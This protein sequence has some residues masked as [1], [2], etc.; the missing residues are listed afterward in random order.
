[1]ARH[2]T[3][4]ADFSEVKDKG[5]DPELLR[6]AWSFAKPYR[7]L[8]FIQLGVIVV[9]QI[10]SV[11]PPVL[12]KVVIDSAIPNRDFAM[13][14]WIFVAGVGLAIA[15]TGLNLVGRWLDARVGEGLIF[16]L[17]V[18]LYDHVQRMP[19][20]FFTR[21]Q[22]GALL[23][24][25]SSDVVGAQRTVVQVSTVVSDL[26][27]LITTLIAMLL[28][29]WRVTLLAL[30]VVP[31]F[32]WLDRRL[33]RRLA[34]ISRERMQVDA[35][36]SGVMAERFNVSGAALVKLFGK[37]EREAS[38]FAERADAVRDAGIRSALTYRTYYGAV[39]MV[40][41]LGTA[42]V[43]WLGGRSVIESGIKVGT[44]V[45]M[46]AL[47]QR[48]YAPLTSLASARV[49]LLVALVS[50][51]RV[52]EIL[53]TKPSIADHPDA[54][55]IERPTGR[56]QFDQ[57]C[58]SYPG[59]GVDTVA[60]LAAV[61]E[62]PGNEPVNDATDPETI[63]KAS[64][65][66]KPRQIL[67]DISFEVEPGQTFALVGPSG[68][69]KTTIASLLPRLY[70]VTSGAIKLDGYD[71]RDLT[72]QSVRDAVGVVSQDAHL[73]HESIGSNLRFA[74]PDATDDEMMAAAKAARI[75]DV[76]ARLPKGY[77]TV[78][79]ERGYRL[80]GGEKQRLAIARML[81]K[82]PAVV[83]LDEATAHLD[84]ETEGLVQ[85]ALAA[86]LLNRSAIVI[87]HRLSTIRA[88]DQILVIDDGRIV[89]QGT[90]EQLL[91]RGGLYKELY[92]TQYSL[93]S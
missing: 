19:L 48:L 49:D 5:I 12:F 3:K 55:V 69:G 10:A 88:A 85:E 62:S 8:L 83:V 25:L 57:V 75:H 11:L 71:V 4:P 29:D 53:D 34:T 92:E 42:A 14:N 54:T 91:S 15:S 46:A 67:Y 38:K 17:R 23:S 51:E 20:P 66:A 81:L 44:L 6:R 36:M 68:A 87:A 26:V 74:K 84:S 21:T 90:H 93:E 86:A 72:L 9:T 37:P 50:F 35:G 82:A 47:V 39:A 18:A 73:F 78:V 22:T 80:S 32:I 27:A 40:S 24:R 89:Q 60:S 2:G 65:D 16:D 58:F 59:L 1:M 45:A 61:S 77:D 30:T 13:V 33:G 52:F 41:A 31:G 63:Q 76:I 70:D 79:G 43:Y 7:G 64:S 56:V 28:F